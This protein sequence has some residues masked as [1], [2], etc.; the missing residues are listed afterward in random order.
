MVSKGWERL[1]HWAWVGVT[2]PPA[3]PAGV[4]RAVLFWDSAVNDWLK[5]I[6]ANLAYSNSI[7]RVANFAGGGGC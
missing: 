1:R 5:F 3:Q 6:E 4:D 2:E 7:S